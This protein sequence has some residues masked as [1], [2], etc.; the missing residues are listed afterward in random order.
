MVVDNMV[1]D[2]IEQRWFI[3]LDWYRLNNRSFQIQAGGSLCRKC[4]RRLK[5]K[6]GEISAADMITTIKDCC[7]RE[8]GFISDELPILES[9]FR[10]LLANG[11]QPLG[12]EGISKQLNERH[13]GSRYSV[14]AGLLS[15]LLAN[16]Q[17]Y[18]LR[19]AA[20]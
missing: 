20:E 13:V 11:N 10:L 8:S 2:Q 3:D 16:D 7:S 1:L 6:G 17:Y 15:R 18:G 5:K 12:L 19:P 9:V 14:S 4:R